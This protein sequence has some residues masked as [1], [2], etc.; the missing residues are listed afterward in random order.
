MKK[1][2]VTT[3]GCMLYILYIPCVIAVYQSLAVHS[4]GNHCKSHPGHVFFIIRKDNYGFPPDH[5]LYNQLICGFK[6]I[7]MTGRVVFVNGIQRAEQE[8]MF[9]GNVRKRLHLDGKELTIVIKTE[10]KRF[11]DQN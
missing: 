3:T 6:L 5:Y 8:F 7:Q 9:V 1:V 2:K 4:Q 11:E 10:P